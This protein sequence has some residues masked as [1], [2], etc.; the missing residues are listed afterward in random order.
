[1]KPSIGNLYPI[2]LA[3]DTMRSR[4]FIWVAILVGVTLAL[5]Q[6]VAVAK[7]VSE[8]EE[9]AKSATVGIKLQP[10][11]G[12]GSGVIIQ[13]QGSLYTLVTNRHVIC[14]AGDCQLIPTDSVFILELPDGQKYKVP[15]GA[16]Q[17]LG[18]SDNILD[19]AIIRFR[20]NRNYAVAKLAAQGSLKVEDKVY[21]SG[22]PCEPDS[23]PCR[24]L[25]YTFTIGKAIAVVNKRLKDDNGGYT[26]IYDAFTLP[27]M[28]GGG[29]FDSNGQ[30]VAIHGKGDR[31]RENTDSDRQSLIGSKIG[32]NR[33]IPVRWIRQGF[34]MAGISLGSASIA[35]IQDD[36]PQ[37]LATADEYFIAGFNKFIDPGNKDVL[38]GKRQAIEEL[39][40]AI[41]LN[42][43]Y[44]YAYFMR[45]FIYQQIRDSQRSLADYNQVIILNPKIS[46]TYN[47]RGLLK[48]EQFNDIQGA[49]ADFNQS[50]ILDPKDSD[51]YNNRAT[52]KYQKFNDIQG[53]LTDYDQAIL[54]SPK[55]PAIY[56]NR[57]VLKDDRLNDIKG[58]LADYDQAI[59]LNPEYSLPYFNRAKLKD[60]TFNDIKGALADCDEAISFNPRDPK[61]YNNRAVFKKKLNDFQGALADY[62]Q[63]ISLNP[64]Y[65]KAYFNRA[66][67]KG[68]DGAIQDLR[69]AAQLFRA[70]G[71]TQNLQLV[72]INLKFL[73]STE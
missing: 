25:G 50:L 56:N 36:S 38:I 30:L 7:S 52:L 61:A 26:I 70:Q 19:L 39:S 71:N 17:L 1:M 29:V 73:G 4:L 69:Q 9:I 18:N 63:A 22:F 35:N 44:E 58:A 60:E 13:R 33:G 57:A 37:L 47:N 23:K 31:Y 53:A 55:S 40:K 48:D 32:Y 28:S 20:S 11:V 66:K 8:V 49:L 67:L 34:T 62:D 72:I 59:S 51:A 6:P 5:V 27:G 65:A 41:K 46:S 2:T 24:S 45:A 21:A 12:K 43:Q 10:R 15:N 68:R 64:K 42:P 14:G 54:V 16:I 3:V